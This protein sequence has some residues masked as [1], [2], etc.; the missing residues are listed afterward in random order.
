M[1]LIRALESAN[2]VMG[3]AAQYTG[4]ACATRIEA[5][6]LWRKESARGTMRAR[7]LGLNYWAAGLLNFA[8]STGTLCLISSN[9]M[10]S[11]NSGLI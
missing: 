2:Y 4:R 3:F 10:V 11:V 6:C 8:S 9:L 7:R 5:N 1:T